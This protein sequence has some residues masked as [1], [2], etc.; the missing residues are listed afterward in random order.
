M[1]LTGLIG[2]GSFWLVCVVLNGPSWFG[3]FWVA[4]LV[5]RVPIWFE[6]FRV[7]LSGLGGF[8]CV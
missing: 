4:W 2:L 6:W 7:V 8:G 5:L 3:W 1:G